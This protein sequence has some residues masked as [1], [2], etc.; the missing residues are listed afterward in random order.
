MFSERERR[1]ARARVSE[2]RRV[3]VCLADA[4][5]R[6]DMDQEYLPPALV[7]SSTSFLSRVSTSLCLGVSLSL[8]LFSVSVVVDSRLLPWYVSVS[9]VDLLLPPSCSLVVAGLGSGIEQRGRRHRRKHGLL[10]PC[11]GHR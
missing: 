5:T 1:R 10:P 2:C 7:V 8:S 9:V 4:A 11:C 6:S 3:F